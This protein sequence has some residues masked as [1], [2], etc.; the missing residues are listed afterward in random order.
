MSPQEKVS[1][2]KTRREKG[3]RRSVGETGGRALSRPRH[4]PAGLPI[5]SQV[6]RKAA[7]SE[8]GVP[9]DS[10]GSW[11]SVLCLK[12]PPGAVTGPR[13]S[14]VI[15][16]HTM[17]EGAAAGC[18]PPAGERARHPGTGG[19]RAA[20]GGA[21]PPCGVS[22]GVRRER[23]SRRR[24][25]RSGASSTAVIKPQ[26]ANNQGRRCSNEAS[27]HSGPL[28]TGSQS[29]AGPTVPG[30]RARGSDMKVPTPGSSWTTGIA[31]SWGGVEVMVVRGRGHG[32]GQRSR[33]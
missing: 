25:T 19:L 33:W 28:R 2:N 31:R 32:E 27:F 11:V 9:G 4:A 23:T 29:E 13:N 7:D 17:L 24:Q 21:W 12:A 20:W 14:S 8:A 3:R 26:R 16:D 18:W 22:C 30:L 5:R 1:K 15:S 10:G 6:N